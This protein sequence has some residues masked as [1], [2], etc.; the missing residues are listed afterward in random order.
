MHTSINHGI[1][2][3]R[4]EINKKDVY[5]YSAVNDTAPCVALCL[6]Y[7]P[8]CRKHQQATKK[9][10]LWQLPAILVIHLKRFSYNKVWRDKLDI[11]IDYPTRCVTMCIT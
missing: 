8:R 9:F 5:G 10:D 4:S 11:T 6:R 3:L 2:R 1:Q 7:C